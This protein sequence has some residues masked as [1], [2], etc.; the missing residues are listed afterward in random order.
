MALTSA[1]RASIA[2]PARGRYHWPGIHAASTPPRLAPHVAA[3]ARERCLQCGPCA[4]G[5]ARAGGRRARACGRH[6]AHDPDRGGERPGPARS[7]AR[8]AGRA[9]RRFDARTAGHRSDS[10]LRPGWPGACRLEREN[11]GTAPDLGRRGARDRNGDRS[12]GRAAG[13]AIAPGGSTSCPSSIPID[14]TGA[15]HAPRGSRWRSPLPPRM[16]RRPI[17]GPSAT[18]CCGSGR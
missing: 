9:P 16:A 2:R 14:W 13:G 11:G 12:G 10:P 6:G 7:A 3:P 4:A 5:S 1:F 8:R 18:Y 15:A 17:G